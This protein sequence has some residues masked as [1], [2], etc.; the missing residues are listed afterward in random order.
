MHDIWGA[1]IGAFLI[2]FLSFEWLHFFGEFEVIVYGVILLLVVIFLPQGMVGIP[3]I[4]KGLFNR[5]VSNG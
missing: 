3:K 2:T 4:L 5:K 1:I